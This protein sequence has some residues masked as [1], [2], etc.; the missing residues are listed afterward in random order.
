VA[1]H[2]QDEMLDRDKVV[3]ER[4]GLVL[5]LPKDL[6]RSPRKARLGPPGDPWQRLGPLFEP[7]HEGID[8]A[9][10]LLNQWPGYAIFLGEHRQE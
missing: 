7:Q 6:K 8:V 9:F 1:R 2:R 10:G 4:L 3:L 5:R